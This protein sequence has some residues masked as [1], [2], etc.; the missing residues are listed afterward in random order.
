MLAGWAWRV[1]DS[2]KA[3]GYSPLD[4]P[5]FGGLVLGFL[6]TERDRGRSGSCRASFEVEH[7]AWRR[8]IRRVKFRETPGVQPEPGR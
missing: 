3:G 1:I 2:E 5:L 6:E 8:M 7:T 4:F